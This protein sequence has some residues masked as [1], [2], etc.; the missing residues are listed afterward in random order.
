M[1]KDQIEALEK[2]SLKVKMDKENRNKDIKG[3]QEMLKN[4]RAKN[5]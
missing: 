2:I 1:F 4:I 5:V 3:L